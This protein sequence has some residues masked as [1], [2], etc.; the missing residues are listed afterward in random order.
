MVSSELWVGS[1]ERRVTVSLRLF[2][3]VD[4]IVST[5]SSSLLLMG[6]REDGS[7]VPVGL[8]RLVV[9]RRVL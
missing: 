1:V 2:D 6:R 9:L 5:V 7:P 8:L 3:A 4:A